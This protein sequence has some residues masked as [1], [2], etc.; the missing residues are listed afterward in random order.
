MPLSRDDIIVIQSAILRNM[1]EA[2]KPTAIAIMN[3]GLHVINQFERIT[4]AFEQI[5]TS[6]A[7]ISQKSVT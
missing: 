5:A 2:E 7:V 1:P 4:I 6:L 3:V